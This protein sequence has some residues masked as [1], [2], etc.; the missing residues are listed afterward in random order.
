MM[1]EIQQIRGSELRATDGTIGR[2]DD[3]LFDERGWRVRYFVVD[4]GG[5]LGGRKVVIA[6]GAVAAP[7][8]PGCLPVNLTLEQVRHSPPVDAAQPITRQHEQQLAEHYGWLPG[9]LAPGLPLAVMAAPIV[10]V[11][12]PVSMIPPTTPP[13][14]EKPATPPA[15]TP[16]ESAAAAA[17]PELRSASAVKN[18]SVE[19]SDGSIGH[20]EEL[21]V[22]DADWGVRYF[23]IDTR[24]WLP[25]RHVV[26]A[27]QWVQGIDWDE[28]AVQVALRRESIKN[29]PLYD[30]TQTITPEFEERVR[31]HY[32]HLR[33]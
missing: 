33:P 14:A 4:C 5:W 27:P 11:A 19:A 3:V 2:I 24:N 22:D 13:G 15:E 32:S 30:R 7:F 29:S 28:R 18:C 21:V 20:V 6:T 10:G 12:G 8:A 26:I 31:G 17:A 25:G 23:V 9:W 16:A 1:R